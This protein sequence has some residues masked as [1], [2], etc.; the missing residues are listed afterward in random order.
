[1][2]FSTGKLAIRSALAAGLLAGSAVMAAGPALAAPATPAA[3]AASAAPAARMAPAQAGVFQ[4]WP[5]AQKAA[6][7]LLFAPHHTAGLKR[8]PVLDVSRCQATKKVRFDVTAQWGGPKVHF[9]FDQNNTSFACLGAPASATPPLAVYKVKGVTYTLNG[10]CGLASLPPCTSK[11]ALLIMTWK[12]GPHFYTA[13]SQ[14]FLRGA[15]L[16]FATSLKKI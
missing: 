11:A 9:L 13:F 12:V 4:T 10:A 6:E 3:P 1:M 16:N 5:A 8:V 7:F 14:G 2:M 15:L